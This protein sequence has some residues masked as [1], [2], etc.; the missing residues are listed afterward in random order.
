M[1]FYRG[2]HDIEKLSDYA[3]DLPKKA[4]HMT[5][6]PIWKKKLE[7]FSNSIKMTISGVEEDNM[8]L[9]VEILDESK[10][11]G[12]VY[13][14]KL[15]VSNKLKTVINCQGLIVAGNVLWFRKCFAKYYIYFLLQII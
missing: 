2:D 11:F 8:E 6:D 1:L 12:Q 4:I 15:I 3:M 14:F 9:P 7:E 5:L 10:Y 13:I